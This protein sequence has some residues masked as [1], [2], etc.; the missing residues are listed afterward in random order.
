MASLA[1]DS[2]L[3]ASSAPALTRWDDILRLQVDLS[4][5][6][7][8]AC[9]R[10]LP[11]WQGAKLILDAGCG[12]GYFVS[13]LAAFFPD[14]Q[15]VG[16]D[17][18]PDLIDLARRRA[19]PGNAS[20]AQSDLFAHAAAVPYDLV[21][22]RFLVQHLSDLDA[23]LR[24]AR[25]LLRSGG[26]LLIVEPDFA[27]SVNLP[28]MP[29]F[30]ELFERFERHRIAAGHIPVR[31][32]SGAALLAGVPG[33]RVVRDDRIAVPHVGPF[34]GHLR[35]VFLGWIEL[36][37]TMSDFCFDGRAVRREVEAWT[38]RRDAFTQITLK[39]VG[40]APV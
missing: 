36:C 2:L 18:S 19:H 27:A 14:K 11:S 6:H 33:W 26:E 4:F 39:V 12:N 13:R 34:D 23:L 1:Q 38:A 40:L 37:E 8:L 30:H 10:A 5:A 25:T 32:E 35:Q 22:M 21:L 24:H 3:E 17:L 31:T 15:F 28:P 20:F 9:L 7:E 29:L 16:I